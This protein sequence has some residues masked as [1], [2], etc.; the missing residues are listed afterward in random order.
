MIGHQMAVV[1]NPPNPVIG[2]FG[3]AFLLE[4]DAG[5]NH[6]RGSQ[7]R[8]G[9][10]REPVLQILIHW[11]RSQSRLQDGTCPRGG[12]HVHCHALT[13]MLIHK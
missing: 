4:V 9:N 1:F 10:C 5:V 2:N 13:G 3:F 8:Q 11:P 7:Q 6:G 12:L